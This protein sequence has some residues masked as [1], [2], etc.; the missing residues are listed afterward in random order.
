MPRIHSFAPLVGPGARI[1]ILGSMPGEASLRAGQYY[2]HPRNLFW[3]VMGEH[4]GA[5]PDLP[6][7]ERCAR[8]L[9]HGIALWDVLGSCERPGS[10]DAAIERESVIT[11]DFV[12]FFRTW[13]EI[14]RLLF[15]GSMAESSFRR[16][17]QP[18]LY[19]AGLPARPATRLPSTS[20]AHAAVSWADKLA[21]WQLALA[22]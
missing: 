2:A 16:H 11:N 14:Q 8:L 18:E 5:G 15:N 12:H 17:V 7:P 19:A 22:A 13:P 21:A 20:P 10:L 4:C 6:Y 9:A 1:L 3:R